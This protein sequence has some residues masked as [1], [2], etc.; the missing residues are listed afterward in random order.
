V[1]IDVGLLHLVFTD[2]A[3]FD[4]LDGN[5]FKCGEF[6][7]PGV[8]EIDAGEIFRQS[9]R[10]RGPLA[11]SKDVGDDAKARRIIFEAVE[12]KRGPFLFRRALGQRADFALQV[13]AFERSDLAHLFEAA[14]ESSHV[15]DIAHVPS[16]KVIL[17]VRAGSVN[18]T[19]RS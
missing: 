17:F 5:R 8:E 10:R 12:K 6:F 3:A 2:G 13:D 4:L 15:R 16:K 11:G 1:E 18:S 9:H 19:R 7:P 14:E